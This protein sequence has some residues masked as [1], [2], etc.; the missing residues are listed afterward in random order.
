M[1]GFF[2]LAGTSRAG[3]MKI[4]FGNLAPAE[5]LIETLLTQAA[6]TRRHRS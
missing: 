5:R 6:A 2:H 1:K 4:N 3:D